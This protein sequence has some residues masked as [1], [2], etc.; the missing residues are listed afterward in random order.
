MLKNYFLVAIRHLKRQPGYAFLNIMGLTIGIAS[1]L[2]IILYLNQELSYDT[3]HKKAGQVYRI[4]TDFTE[5][6]NSF[7]WATTQPVLGRTVKEEFQEVKQY[8]RFAGGGD[9]RLQLG[10]ISYIAEDMYLVD[11]TIFNIFTFNFLQGDKKTALNAPNSIVISKSFSDKVFKGENPMGQLLES[12][13]FSYKV[14]GV[15]EDVPKTSHITADA[16]ASFSTNQNFYSNSNWG[17]WQLYTYILI[18]ENVNPEVVEARLNEEII[19]KYVATIFDQFDIQI[20][21][22]LINIKD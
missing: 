11:S 4:S 12:D 2:L 15:Y 6:D 1:A 22:E 3:H 7:R 9:T 20:K 13:N 17:A 19:P 8:T 10:N 14:T 21:Y 18:N 5:P 16:L